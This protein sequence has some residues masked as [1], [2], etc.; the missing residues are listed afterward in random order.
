MSPSRISHNVLGST[1]IAAADLSIRNTLVWGIG[2][3]AS[4][5]AR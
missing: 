5:S 2:L 4:A 1:K 3:S